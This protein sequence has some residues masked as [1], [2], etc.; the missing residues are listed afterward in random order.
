MR[1]T[2]M[3]RLNGRVVVITGGGSG[4]GL[5]TA[6]LCLAE[7]ARVAICG[8]T[9]SKIQ[10]AAESLNGGANL[11]ATAC[12]VTVPDKVAAFVRGVTAKFGRIDIL[13]N[14]AG[15]NI[16]NRTMAEMTPESW[17]AMIAAN[18]DGAFYWTA[19][20]LPQMRERKDGVIININS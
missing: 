14:N 19:A 3:G 9:T 10:A 7:R 13:V 8:R 17:Q 2:L 1:G 15:T 4:V 11:F 16:K 6:K 18:L 20:V 12:D 5:A